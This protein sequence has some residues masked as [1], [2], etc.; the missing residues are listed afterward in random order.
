MSELQRNP[1]VKDEIRLSGN[2]KVS[3]LMMTYPVHQAA[4]ILFCHG[5]VV[6]G[7]K[8]QLPH[9]EMTRLIARR[10]NNLYFGGEQY[11]PQTNLLLSSTPLLLGIDGR[12]MGKSLNNAIFLGMSAD[13]TAIRIKGAKT[14]SE[15]HIY[16]DPEKRPEVSNLLLLLS[17][18]TG[19]TPDQ[20]GNEIG[21]GG[22]SVLKNKLTEAV[23]E[24]F[25]EMRAI[26]SNLDKDRAYIRS[27]LAE[28]NR[29]ANAVA[30]Q[31]MEDLRRAMKMKYY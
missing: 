26:R 3:G 9:V 18:C 21:S 19:A 5:N 1:T 17:L 31:T 10:I 25:K 28:G 29:K 6:P 20:L 27:V 13:E 22:S 8:D 16:Y 15:K 24:Y 12:K 23:N 11:F 7:G 4:D 30:D 14:D 2:Q